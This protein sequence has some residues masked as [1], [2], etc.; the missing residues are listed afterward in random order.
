M[1]VLV[2]GAKGRLGPYVVQELESAGHELVLMDRYWQ[3]LDGPWPR[4]S[5]DIT[6]F[7]T[8]LRATDDGVDAIQHLAAVAFPSDHPREQ[9]HT[10]DG[11]LRFDATIR[12]NVIGTYNL[13]QA[14]IRRDIGV[15]VMTGSYCAM[16][17]GYRISETLFP[18]QYLPVDEQ[19]PCYV[20]DSY[21]FSKLATE[22]LLASYARA[23]GMRTYAIRTASIYPPARRASHAAAGAPARGW[24][25]FL[26]AW[27]GSEDLASAQRLLM[28]RAPDTPDH[29]VFFCNADDTL[30]LEPTR[31]LIE[32]FRPELLPLATRMT[33]HV[34]L[35]SSRKL[36]EVVGWE[37]RTSWR[38]ARSERE[39]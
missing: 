34:S 33:G 19:H 36:Y 25:P 16:G 28:E 38:D 26:W 10:F 18:F 35:L 6:D 12:T 22:E 24:D 15:F 4:V 3:S 29:G 37:P 8:C 1:K 39:S 31:D 7:Q 32:R 20:E 9:H 11:G 21:S 5:G 14:A 2:T 27:V 30:A 17:S 23:Y 13:L